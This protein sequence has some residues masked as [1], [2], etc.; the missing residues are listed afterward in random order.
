MAGYATFAGIEVGDRFPETPLHFDVTEAQVRGFLEATGNTDP[1]YGP[2]TGSAPS[3]LAS[4]YLVDL[5]KAR[6]SP[7]GGIHAKQSMRFARALRVGERLTLSA[8]VVEKYIRRERPYVISDFTATDSD[9]QVVAR[10]RITS[11]W[12]TSA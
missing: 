5:L 10:G 4:V 3:M 11:I 8:S 2:D 6:N 12:G 9:G 1:A 7:P